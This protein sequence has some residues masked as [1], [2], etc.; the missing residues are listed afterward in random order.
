MTVEEASKLTGISRL[1]IR[2]GL[3][4]GQ[5]PFGCAVKTSEN[6]WT[7]HIV[8]KKVYDYIGEQYVE[9]TPPQLKLPRASIGDF[10][11][12]M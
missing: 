4:N 6:R 11:D 3:Q 2:K 1:S 10:Y 8:D 12:N 7:Y 9:D 5:L